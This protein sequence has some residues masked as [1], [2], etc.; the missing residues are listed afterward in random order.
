[1]GTLSKDQGKKI[2]NEKY[3]INLDVD[4]KSK[5]DTTV[6]ELIEKGLKRGKSRCR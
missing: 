1:M 5:F 3:K 4:A 6:N 2:W